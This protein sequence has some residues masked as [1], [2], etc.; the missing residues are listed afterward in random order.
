M[1]IIF[2]SRFMNN[3]WKVCNKLIG[4]SYLVLLGL[5][6]KVSRYFVANNNFFVKRGRVFVVIL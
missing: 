3:W 4:K 6:V 2:V 5:F 1:W